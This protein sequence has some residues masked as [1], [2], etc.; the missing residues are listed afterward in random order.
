MPTV[1]PEWPEKNL[2]AMYLHLDKY[3]D[4]QV[5]V[6]DKADA[7][8]EGREVWEASSWNTRRPIE[9]VPAEQLLRT[10]RGRLAESA[11]RIGGSF[12]YKS[13][14]HDGKLYFVYGQRTCLAK[15]WCQQESYQNTGRCVDHQKET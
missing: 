12:M 10:L 11:K 1:L 14:I 15:A 3:M 5:W 2:S 8:E 4:G 7:I 9:E 6:F 13:K